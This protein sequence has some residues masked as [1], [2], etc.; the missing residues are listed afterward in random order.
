MSTKSDSFLQKV[1]NGHSVHWIQK[2]RL[3]SINKRTENLQNTKNRS[4]TVLCEFFLFGYKHWTLPY[5]K[6][7][8]YIKNSRYPYFLFN[9]AYLHIS[10]KYCGLGTRF[11]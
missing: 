2:P 11:I 9:D 1:E 3:I 6:A 7:C 4:H 10:N 5:K 8:L